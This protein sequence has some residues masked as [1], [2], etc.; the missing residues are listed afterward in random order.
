MK[1]SRIFLFLFALFFCAFNFS[2]FYS[3]FDLVLSFLNG[4]LEGRN[5]VPALLLLAIFSL[6]L[7]IFTDEELRKGFSQYALLG[8]LFG[9]PLLRE[10]AGVAQSPELTTKV[11]LDIVRKEVQEVVRERYNISS[12]QTS[13]MLNR[14]EGRLA[15]EF[16]AELEEK[17]KRR[18]SQ[19]NV[20][21]LYLRSLE[22]LRE[23]VAVL[24]SRANTSLMFGIIFSLIG[25]F[26]LYVTFFSSLDLAVSQLPHSSL[27]FD[28]LDLMR[29]YLPRLSLV[30]IIELISF[31]FL[32]LYSK[33]LNELRYAQNE[34]TNVELKIIALVS[35][36]AY[37][38]QESTTS[39]IKSLSDTERNNIIDKSQSTIEIER[40]RAN[41]EGEI[42]TIN[43]IASLLHGTE[44]GWFWKKRD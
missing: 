32:R 1:A 18:F 11:V 8:F 24:G 9:G 29:E 30:I 36:V 22:R 40:E 4:L 31:F 33:A 19:S 34:T 20:E 37:G 6:L 7:G 10:G 12:E 15:K 3:N 27:D 14:L 25:L 42:S 39:V 28:F 35:S 38:L 21:E 16:S 13:E 44:K 26:A 2:L 17:M 5:L 43:A 23:Q 41:S